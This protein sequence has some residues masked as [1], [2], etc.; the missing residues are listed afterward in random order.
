M[1]SSILLLVSSVWGKG[2]SGRLTCFS[3]C[4][5][6]EM[7]FNAYNRTRINLM[8]TSYQCIMYKLYI[9]VTI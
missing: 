7:S 5:W 3:K 4:R 1:E 9:R 8:A 2:L 6:T